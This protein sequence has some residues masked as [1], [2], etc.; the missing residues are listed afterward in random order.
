MALAEIRA[1]GLIKQNSAPG[2]I[3]IICDL[4][5]LGERGLKAST[6][7]IAGADDID[8]KPEG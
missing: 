7:E 3:Q 4:G 8:G 6:M 1:M 2:F 5:E